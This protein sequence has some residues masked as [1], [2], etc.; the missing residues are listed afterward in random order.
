MEWIA[1]HDPYILVPSHL[2]GGRGEPLSIRRTDV[3]YYCMLR[4]IEIYVIS[5]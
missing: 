4:F 1:L 5:L 2:G 3:F